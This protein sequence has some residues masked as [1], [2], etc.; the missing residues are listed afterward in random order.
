MNKIIIAGKI[1]DIDY[2]LVDKGKI[3]GISFSRIKIENESEIKVIF[4][5]DLADQILRDYNI[6]DNIVVDGFL[7][8]E[9]GKLFIIANEIIE[10]NF[11][12]YFRKKNGKV[13]KK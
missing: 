9:K 5:N 11:N 7:R 6:N 3:F 1:I 8:A 12:K 4:I 2:K 10:W 13:D